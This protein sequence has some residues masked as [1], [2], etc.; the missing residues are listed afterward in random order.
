MSC[1]YAGV[2][3]ERRQVVFLLGWIAE[4]L[5]DW[6]KLRQLCQNLASSYANSILTSTSSIALPSLC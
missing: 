5:S 4:M 1:S 6:P 2:D 3:C